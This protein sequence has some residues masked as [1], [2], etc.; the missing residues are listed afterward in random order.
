M[1]H[2]IQGREV[3]NHGKLSVGLTPDISRPAYL[4]E[5]H[6]L[7]DLPNGEDFGDVSDHLASFH[8][9][10]FIGADQENP[11]LAMLHTCDLP[12]RLSDF[13]VPVTPERRWVVSGFAPNGLGLW[14]LA[15]IKPAAIKPRESRPAGLPADRIPLIS[16]E[17]L[18]DALDDGHA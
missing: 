16:I 11:L 12:I 9:G 5:N 3:T 7:T 4:Q 18:A 1:Q 15:K 13:A 6:N 14:S 17:Q 10:G 2:Q 8:A